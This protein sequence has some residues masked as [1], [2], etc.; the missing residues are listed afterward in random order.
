ML[1]AQTTVVK[2][3]AKG[4]EALSRAITAYDAAGMRMH[5]AA[6]RYVHGKLVKGDEGRAES[7]TA[8]RY[9]RDEGVL[10]PERFIAMLLPV[11]RTLT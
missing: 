11:A 6:C 9:F 3:P 1:D 8:V 2:A 10:V 7:E 4:P 5:A